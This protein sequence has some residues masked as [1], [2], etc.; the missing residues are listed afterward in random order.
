MNQ[1]IQLR[2]GPPGFVQADTNDGSSYTLSYPAYSGIRLYETQPNPD[3]PSKTALLFP[4]FHTGQL[5]Y[6]SGTRELLL[7]EDADRVLPQRNVAIRVKIEAM[8][9]VGNSMSFRAFPDYY[10]AHQPSGFAVQHKLRSQPP[11]SSSVSV[12]IISKQILTPTIA[13]LRFH[14][15]D[16]AHTNQWTPG[17]YVV[18]GFESILGDNPSYKYRRESS[19][20][21]DAFNRKFTVSSGPGQVSGYSEFEITIR[22]VGHVTETLLYSVEGDD[23]GILLRGFH[24][25]FFFKQDSDESIGIIA[26]GIGVTPL[27]SQA[28]G[29]DLSR[30]RVFWAVRAQDLGLVLDS[31]KREKGLISCTRLFVTSDVDALGSAKIA[32][33]R[34]MDAWVEQRRMQRGDLQLDTA[35]GNRLRKW[36]ICAGSQLRHTLLKWLDGR[37]VIFETFTY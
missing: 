9:I 5:L 4:D 37:N 21:D 13:R 33:L 26:G 24:G 25:E 7:R 1:N 30:V 11:E 3:L 8:R 28:S 34:A 36:Y 12:E 18:L 10:I 20:L 16:S 2:S 19:S 32:E 27:L 22:N 29:L 14:I 35:S 6:I 31:Y 17:Q 23:L 15:R